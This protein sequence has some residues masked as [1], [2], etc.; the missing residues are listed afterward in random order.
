[1]M[2]QAIQVKE[3]SKSYGSLSALKSLTLSVGRGSVFGLLGAN[4]AGQSTAIECMLGTRRPDGGTVRILG[5]DPRSERKKLF[6]RVGRPIPGNRLP[7]KNHSPGALR[8]HRFPL[9]GPG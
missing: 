7:G 8:G 2:E 6:Q 5:K 3:L 1:M 4:G 9:P